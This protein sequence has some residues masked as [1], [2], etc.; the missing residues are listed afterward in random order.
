MSKVAEECGYLF[1]LHDQ[2]RDYYVDGSRFTEARAVRAADGTH[3]RKS[4]WAGGPQTL[5]CAREAIADIRRNFTELIGRGV[6]LTGSYLDV[7]AVVPLDECYNI[8]HPM[9][10]ED[11]Y[12]WRAAGLDYVRGLG[13]PISSEEPV[14]CFIAASGLRVLGAVCEDG[15]R[16][17]RLR[18]HTRAP[19]QSRL[20]R[21]ALS[22]GGV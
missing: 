2:Y 7:Y 3:P 13:L 8:E 20:S 1:G 16:G 5:L 10:R 12:R 11:C 17:G 9:T 4:L 19:S 21:R 22:A 14:D 18:R 15:L 6:K